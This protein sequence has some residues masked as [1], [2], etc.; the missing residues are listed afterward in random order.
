MVGVDVSYWNGYNV[1][2]EKAKAAGID[3]AIVRAGYGLGN[4]DSTADGNAKRAK[5][6][7][8]HVGY[9]W[10]SYAATADE[11][12]KEADYCCDAIERI[13]VSPDFPVCFDFEYDSEEKAPPKE[14]IVSIA[15]AFLSRVKVRGY[16]PANY[17]N[18]DYLSRGF[19]QLVGEYDLWLAQ[20]GVSKPGRECGIWQYTS[21]GSPAGF[22]GNVDMNVAYKDYPAIIGGDTPKPEPKPEP[23]EDKCVAELTV[24]K[25]GSKGD[26]VKS[27]QALLNLW[28]Y[29]AGSVDGIFGSKT[30]RAVTDLQTDCGLVSDGIVGAKTW[31]VLVG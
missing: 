21:T 1:D 9:Y 24:I 5:E 11:A 3:F 18:Y 7:G 25:Y 30:S 6:A 2:W 22:S 10:F 31:S 12:R 27:A 13:G 4:L 15:R 17:T 28:G 19:D 29:N 26:A 8:V 20:W 14:S 23:T 16:Y